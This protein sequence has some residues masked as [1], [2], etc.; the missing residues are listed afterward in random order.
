MSR[1]KQD[2]EEQFKS[3][4]DDHYARLKR[5]ATKD[6]MAYVQYVAKHASLRSIEDWCLDRMKR[7]MSLSQ[8]TSHRNTVEKFLRKYDTA[9]VPARSLK[10]SV[11][12]EESVMAIHLNPDNESGIREMWKSL[13]LSFLLKMSRNTRV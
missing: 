6:D 11:V 7:V 12:R 9:E 4:F 2:L 5:T 8:N 13:N 10:A 3:R 1:I